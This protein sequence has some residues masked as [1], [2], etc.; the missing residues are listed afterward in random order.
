M[1]DKNTTHVVICNGWK[2]LVSP[3][4][5]K[6]FQS[7]FD[8]RDKALFAL[9][10]NDFGFL[11]VLEFVVF[12]FYVVPVLKALNNDKLSIYLTYILSVPFTVYTQFCLELII[13]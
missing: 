9:S 6:F 4:F 5:L 13:F 12:V 10:I 1:F 11:I 2:G 3:F 8:T 7:N